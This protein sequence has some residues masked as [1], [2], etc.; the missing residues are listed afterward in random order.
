MYNEYIFV[1]TV[2]LHKLKKN[3]NFLMRSKKLFKMFGINTLLSQLT[4]ALRMLIWY[5]VVTG[6][7]V[8]SILSSHSRKSSP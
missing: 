8:N 2:E 7:L 6:L 5:N 1:F 4:C 3:P